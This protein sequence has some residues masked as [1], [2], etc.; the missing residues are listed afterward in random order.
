MYTIV[1]FTHG[2]RLEGKMPN[3]VIASSDKDLR[4][5][6]RKCSG[7][8]LFF[9]NKNAE[10]REQVTKLLEKI[11]TLVAI[12]GRSC[13]TSAL[14]PSY[15]KKIRERQEK[16]LEERQEDI[17]RKER[18]LAENYEDEEELE[19]KKRELWREEEET[20]RRLAENQQKHKVNLVRTQ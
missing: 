3:D 2:D 16:I 12:N 20:A 15:E 7:G 14:Y 5:F 19:K 18:E 1:I 11:E 6:I 8:F 17:L 10:N 4:H 9:N 13:Y